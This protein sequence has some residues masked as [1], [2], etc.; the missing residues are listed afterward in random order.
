MQTR[1]D[2]LWPW[3]WFRFM[4]GASFLAAIPR[5]A[6]RNQCVPEV[7]PSSWSAE[8]SD[9]A[10]STRAWLIVLFV[11]AAILTC[12]VVVFTVQNCCYWFHC[13]HPAYAAQDAKAGDDDTRS[14]GRSVKEPSACE[15]S[16][17]EELIDGQAVYVAGVPRQRSKSADLSAERQGDGLKL[18]AVFE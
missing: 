13:C 17:P 10:Q 1:C 2:Y 4:N 6:Q 12:C 9:V 14:C 11:L 8:D 15:A 5:N 3:P 18:A 16:A 7:D